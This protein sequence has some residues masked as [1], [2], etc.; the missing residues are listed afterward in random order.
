MTS[1]VLFHA[2][3]VNPGGAER[4][5][6]E[7]YRFLRQA[8]FAVRVLTYGP[9]KE[10]ALYG[11]AFGGDLEFIGGRGIPGKVASLRR[12]LRDLNPD[13]AIT[14]AGLRYLYLATRGLDLPYL[15]HLHEPPLKRILVQRPRLY[16]WAHRRT[17]REL[18]Q[19]P[20][21]RFAPVP[22]GRPLLA[23]LDELLDARCIKAARRVTVLSQQAAREVE[24]LYGRPAVPL[25]GAIR[26][27]GVPAPQNIRD[28]NTILSVCRLD[29]MKRVDLIIEAF[30]RVRK[31][32]PD[33][34][35]LIGGT[36][37][38]EGRL[39]RIA[40]STDARTSI[41]FLG[42]IGEEDLATYY[43]G[44]GV[45]VV[46]D[47]ADF[48][49]TPYEALAAGCN[50]LA[51]TEMEFEEGLLDGNF[52]V[53]ADPTPQAYAA[54]LEAALNLQ[55]GRSVDLTALTWPRYFSAALAPM[56]AARSSESPQRLSVGDF[57][58]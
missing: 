37:S 3:L 16:S 42:Y 40:H 5:F 56:L 10:H 6:V 49:I 39:R 44:A 27:A 22:R 11:E 43:A 41:E 54:G 48:D 51:S 45:F 9:S 33:L 13:M 32:R 26:D 31:T 24:V 34:R 20:L 29:T 30:L 46:A 50:V 15:V 12:R 1:V 52:V 35:L 47:W 28:P 17:I 23:D 55:L 58:P 19:A 7:E 2:K 57:A 8:G 25:R 21:Y 18:R 14:A 38:E 53:Q 4:L 36:G